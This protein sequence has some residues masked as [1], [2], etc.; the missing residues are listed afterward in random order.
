[1]L[2]L[3]QIAESTS[4]AV[5]RS[6]AEYEL[7]DGAS[8]RLHVVSYAREAVIPRLVQFDELTP[9]LTWCEQAGQLEAIVGSF[10]LRR[11]SQLLGDMWIKGQQ[12]DSVPFTAPWNESRG[13][14]SVSADGVM[15]VGPRSK[16]P[17]QPSGDLLQAG[18]LLTHKGVS[19]LLD[20]DN[21]EGFSSASDQFDSDIT[22]GR[23]PRAAIGLSETH[24]YSVVCDGYGSHEPVTNDA[25]LSLP[26]LATVM[27]ELGAEESL[28]LDGGGSSTQISDGVLRNNPRGDGGEYKEGRGILSAIVFEPRLSL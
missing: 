15:A 5:E 24:I 27:V 7:A 6:S 22:V 25:G 16:F 18:P 8:T 10:F 17:A 20:G 23:Y 26:E 1:M 4:I 11:S 3:A 9:L 2:Q 14:L 12:V 28:N 19:L 21:P 13:S